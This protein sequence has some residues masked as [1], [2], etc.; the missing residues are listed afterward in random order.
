[1]DVSTFLL[2]FKEFRDTSPELVESAIQQATRWVD[3]NVWG[4]LAD[5]GV[6]YKAAELLDGNPFG[7]STRMDSTG[8]DSPYKKEFDRM[9]E[10]VSCGSFL[11]AGGP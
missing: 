1:M 11:C 10:I 9:V 6:A 4:T 3:P 7:G 8:G 5:D 2:R